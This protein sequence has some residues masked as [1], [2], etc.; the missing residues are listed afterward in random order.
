MALF[1]LTKGQ[2]AQAAIEAAALRS[3]RFRQDREGD[4][5]RLEAIVTRMEKGRLRRIADEDVLALPVL[6]RTVASSLS[7][8]RET[9]LDA[10]TLAYL[11]SLVQRAWF[12]VYGPRTTLWSW[13]GRFFGGEWGR[14]VRSIWR[15]M[16]VALLLMI[17]G[18]VIGW[19][20][21]LHDP[22]WYYALFPA[23]GDPRV[24]GASAA[25]L[26][27]VLFGNQGQEGLS[28]FAASLF[29]H[30][31][32]VAILC[33]ALGFAFGIPPL[34][35]LIQNTTL[36]GAM[37]W[38][39]DDKGLLIDLIGW[40]SIHGTTE[41][42][43]ILLSGAAGLH[44]GRSMA[45]PGDRSVLEAAAAAGQRAAVVM[46][47][48]VFMLVCAGMLEGLGRQLINDTTQR[49]VVGYTILAFW[50]AYF[51]LF[52]RVPATSDAE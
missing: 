4:W 14:A 23:D 32:G 21:C 16:A 27:E 24:P 40:L 9:S 26:K 1:S 20:L 18:T 44:V 25:E 52:R 39:H 36:L 17:A 13:L 3:D 10:A 34:L 6:Y 47:G 2:E 28:V 48:V 29:S 45:F 7:V 30:N 12:L 33:F 11:E 41:L 37:L 31:A 42:F 19:Q 22:D 38:L 51:F 5:K 46:A 8:A 43:A 15:E 49:L 50:L 35:L